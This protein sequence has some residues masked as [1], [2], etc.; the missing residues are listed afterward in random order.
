ME[1][2]FIF[3]SDIPVFGG[4]HFL[5][6][7]VSKKLATALDKNIRAVNARVREVGDREETISLNGTIWNDIAASA[8][9]SYIRLRVI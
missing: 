1:E 2:L 9:S 5:R 4:N 3:F 8:F 7:S 6:M